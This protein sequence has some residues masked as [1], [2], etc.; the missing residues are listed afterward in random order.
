MNVLCQV[1]FD[2]RTEIRIQVE[3]EVEVAIEITDE[4]TVKVAVDSVCTQLKRQVV[5]WFAHE[6]LSGGFSGSS[7]L[8]EQKTKVKTPA[9]KFAQFP[10]RALR[11]E[12]KGVSDRWS[13]DP[14]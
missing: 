8:S 2:L 7:T 12:L 10:P 1:T 14:P 4:I 6:S 5:Q 13:A 9:T 11:R 3:I